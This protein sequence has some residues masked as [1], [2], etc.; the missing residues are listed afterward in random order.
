MVWHH[1]YGHLNVTSLRK[2]ANEQLV[3]GL[4]RSDVS[5]EMALCES[6]VQKKIHR[7]PFRTSEVKRADAPLRIDSQRC[8]WKDKFKVSEWSRVFCYLCR[9]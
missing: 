9:R 3:K 5:D 6:C 1:R 2:L 7:S 8:M 4:S